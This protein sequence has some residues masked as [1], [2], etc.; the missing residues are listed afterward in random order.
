MVDAGLSAFSVFFTQSPSFLDWQ[1]RMKQAMGKNNAT[2]MF[3]VH[4]IP[5]D[6]Q[7][8]NL[9]DPLPPSILFPLIANIGNLLF[10]GGYIESYRSIGN[11]FLVAFDG[12]DTFSS[13]NIS[14]PCCTNFKQKNGNILHRHI[15]VT[16][17]IVAPKHSKVISL[18]PQFVQP[19]DG[20]DKQDCELA[21]SLRWLT[22]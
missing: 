20:H 19:Q 7:I 18:P 10:D 22:E 14:C 16:P 15:A 21:A 5:S 12:T 13:T 2:S 11:T 4:Q 9:L 8:R 17:V 6:A 1:I 3:G